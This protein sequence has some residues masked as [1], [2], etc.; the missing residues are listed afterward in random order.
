MRPLPPP[1]GCVLPAWKLLPSRYDPKLTSEAQFKAFIASDR[2]PASFAEAVA[3]QLQLRDRL[4]ATTR[5]Q[6][7][8]LSGGSQHGAFGAGFFRGMKASDG[9]PDYDIVTAVSTGAL[10][11]TL[12]F[13][14]NR[15]EPADRTSFPAY[16]SIDRGLGRPG[17][18]NIDDLALGYAI[19]NE[20]DL[21]KV[22]S[23]GYAGAALHGSIAKFTPLRALV[24][25]LITEDTIR[26]VAK[27]AANHRMLFVGITNLDD[28]Y[29]YAVD[30]TKLAAEAVADNRVAAVRDCYIDTLIASSSVPPGVPPVALVSDAAPQA[31][32]YMDGGARFGVFFDQLRGVVSAGKPADVTLIVNGGLYGG[33]WL[34]KNDNPVGKW[35]AVSFGLRAVDILENQ[36]YRLSVADAEDWAVSHGTLHMAFISNENLGTMTMEPDA[37]HYPAGGASCGQASDNDKQASK[38]QEFHATYMRCLIDYGEHR[39]SG[40]RWNKVL[41]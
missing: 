4:V 13:L 9:I 16:M 6:A 39:G 27:E 41:P 36:V 7:L 29:G 17:T 37:W 2:A 35:S 24:A 30:L 25:A 31:N 3:R 18:S 20:R 34:D 28:G 40:D 10:Q 22:S 33:P 15:P 23:L 11:S 32:L 19:G 21:L 8:L 12:V 14:A 5:R 26:D 1:S 38:P